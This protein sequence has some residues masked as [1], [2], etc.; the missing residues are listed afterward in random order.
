MGPSEV[1]PAAEDPGLGRSS[2]GRQTPDE[3][4]VLHTV[5][6]LAGASLARRWHLLLTFSPPCP[7]PK[8][9]CIAVVL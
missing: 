9:L 4:L 5:A 6:P 3:L 8:E 1:G 7:A 2:A